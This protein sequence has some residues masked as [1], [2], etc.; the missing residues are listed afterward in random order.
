MTLNCWNVFITKTQTYDF[1][2]TLTAHEVDVK[3]LHELRGIF[4]TL[5]SVVLAVYFAAYYEPCFTQEK[6]K[7]STRSCLEIR[8]QDEVTI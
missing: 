8:M 7:L 5:T 6:L 3:N 2:H 4:V 1:A